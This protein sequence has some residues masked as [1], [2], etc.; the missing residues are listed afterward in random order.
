MIITN[1]QARTGRLSRLRGVDIGANPH[2]P[3]SQDWDAWQ[4][5]WIAADADLQRYAHDKATRDAIARRPN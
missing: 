2:A 3:Y 5:G 1:A 4:S